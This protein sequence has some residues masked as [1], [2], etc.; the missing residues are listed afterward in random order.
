MN[1]F[2]NDVRKQIDRALGERIRARRKELGMTQK[3]LAKEVNVSMAAVSLWEKGE[4]TPGANKLELI[5]NALKCKLKWLVAGDD[6]EIWETD[7]S[8]NPT[9]PDDLSKL[10][11]IL[12][13]IPENKRKEVLAFAAQKLAEHFKNVEDGL[14]KIKK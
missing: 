13:L 9:D 14:Y 7:E 5:S 12:D 10:R 3:D 2:E 4:S 11:L 6:I 1:E 8:A